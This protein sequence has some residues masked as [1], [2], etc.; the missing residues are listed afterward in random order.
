MNG[1]LTITLKSETCF[2]MAATLD[3]SV[4]T[5]VALD[6]LG[7]PTAPGKTLHGLLRDT[8]LSARAQIDRPG[9]DGSWTGEKLLGREG[10]LADIGKLRIGDAR[11]PEET[12]AWIDWARSRRE[13]PLRAGALREAFLT[14]TVQTAQDRETDAPK[15]ETLRVSRV[16]PRG[17]RLIAPIQATGD[18]TVG[19][20]DLLDLLV[21][22][23]RHAG[24]GRNHGLGHI[25]MAVEWSPDNDQSSRSAPDLPEG[26]F[27]HFRL[28]LT[29]PCLIASTELDPNSR[30]TRPY[31]TGSAIRGAFAAACM[32]RGL[33]TR[34]T[35]DLIASGS[36]RFLNAYPEADGGRAT[37]VPI[38]WR[39]TKKAGVSDT[40]P[41]AELRDEALVFAGIRD[42]EPGSKQRA[43]VKAEFVAVL[44]TFTAARVTRRYA[45]HQRRDRATG[46]TSKDGKSTVFVYESLAPGQS[47][48][49]CIAVK[50]AE[51]SL[52]SNVVSILTSEPLWLGRSARSG[53]GGA[54][55]VQL[56]RRESTVTE[57][58][59]RPSEFTAGEEFLAVLTS[60]AVLRD[61][62]TGEYDPWVLGP[63]MQAALGTSAEIVK[64]F[65]RSGQ[66]RGFNRLWGQSLPSVP[67]A[68]AGSC[69][70][71]RALR[72]IDPAEVARLQSTALGDRVEDGYGCF[73]LMPVAES[74]AIKE[75][76]QITITMPE[77]PE[78]EELIDAQ[79]RLYQSRL[80]V[81]AVR[82]ASELVS[83]ASGKPVTNSLLQRLRVP[84]RA[85]ADWT[86]TYREWLSGGPN[87]LKEIARKALDE[88]RLDGRTLFDWLKTVPTA[89][90]PEFPDEH[91]ERQSG[92]IVGDERA[93]ILFEEEKEHVRLLYVDSVLAALA[94]KE[95]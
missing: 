64:A 90:L 79:R 39:R 29:A 54:P 19:E 86:D 87:G 30:A 13:P 55:T 91:V 7:L 44:G 69:V 5:D 32:R 70:L 88:A 47:F 52:V 15:T 78:P 63:A 8:W 84:L 68:A 27:I 82:S 85:R 2:S 56:L 38:T 95:A 23:T 67:C 50:D 83:R 59:R 72:D 89:A 48:R 20:R 58:G 6:E 61:E 76:R 45:T 73:A 1:E 93:R 26:P 77:Y 21:R 92:R 49:G 51:S 74:P 80:L 33:S 24:L 81:L 31:I 42:R 14:T 18:L 4:D 28:T 94:K 60:D 46:S 10:S 43:A 12:R 36:V 41:E 34:E 16:V 40:Q 71:I 53:Y 65:V 57:S 66:A 22:L 75:A 25:S 11:M 17:T 37:P 9:D 35:T 3:A 62:A